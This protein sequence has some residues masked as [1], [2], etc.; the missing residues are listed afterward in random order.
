M[1]LYYCLYP[2]RSNKEALNPNRSFSQEGLKLKHFGKIRE[3]NKM[4]QPYNITEIAII[5]SFLLSLLY[6]PFLSFFSLFPK[7]CAEDDSESF[8]ELALYWAGLCGC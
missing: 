1:L 5:I 8:L 4:Q 2:V 3:F 6:I 7:Y